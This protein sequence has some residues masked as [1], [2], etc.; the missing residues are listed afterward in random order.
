ME[1]L[2]EWPK[3]MSSIHRVASS[4]GDILNRNQERG[5]ELTRM[6][7]IYAMEESNLKDGKYPKGGIVFELS[8]WCDDMDK[9]IASLPPPKFVVLPW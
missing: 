1:L 5:A 9:T 6:A 4:C 8:R 3:G 7:R 2:I